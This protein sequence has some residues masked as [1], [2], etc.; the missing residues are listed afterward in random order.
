M[1]LDMMMIIYK[2][3]IGEILISKKLTISIAESC[4][5]GL[6]S[7]RLTNIAGSSKYFLGSIIAYSD[8]LKMELLN[9]NKNTLKNNGAVSQ[10]VAR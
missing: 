7:Q 4:T 10:E 3:K 8:K 9:I 2:K 6:I 5:G 1:P